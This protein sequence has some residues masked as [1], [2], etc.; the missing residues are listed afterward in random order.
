MML[1]MI[2]KSVLL[3]WEGFRRR[4]VDAQLYTRIYFRNGECKIRSLFIRTNPAL[5]A[6]Y[7]NVSREGTRIPST[8]PI[9]I[10]REGSSGVAAASRRG[11]RSWV[12]EKTRVRFSV[13]TR[14]HAESGNSS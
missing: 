8:E 1:L 11:V 3:N 5:E 9:L 12:M 10:I 6:L 2:R 4:E 14:V 7:E 13:R